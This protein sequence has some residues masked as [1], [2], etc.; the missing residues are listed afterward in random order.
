MN[1]PS[2]KII[3]FNDVYE[4]ERCPYFTQQILNLSN[5]HTLKI[6][7]GDIL[8]PSFVSNFK[9]G[10]QFIPFFQKIK[11]DGSV[12]GN[13]E[14]D[15]G[16]DVFKEITQKAKIEWLL[17]NYKVKD[18]D[19]NFMDCKDF[20]IKQIGNLKIGYFGIIDYEWILTSKIL[21]NEYDLQEPIAKTKE[22]SA[23]LKS[24]GC[25]FVIAI[26]HCD[27]VSDYLILEH[28]EDVDFVLGGHVHIYLAS[29]NSNRLM[30]KS[31]FDFNTFSE[32]VVTETT[33]SA[34]PLNTKS[35]TLMD[36]N[37][38]TKNEVSYVLQ[39]SVNGKKVNYCVQLIRHNVDVNGPYEPVLMEDLLKIQEEL[40]EETKEPL[41]YFSEDMNMR[42]GFIRANESKIGNLL[43]DLSIVKFGTDFALIQSGHIR[44]ETLYERR[45]CFR[46]VDL[47][48]TLPLKNPSEVS[49]LT[50]RE[51]LIVL[52]QGLLG[53]PTPKGSFPNIAGLRIEYD[54]SKPPM[55]RISTEKVLEL[56]PWFDLDKT[57]SLVTKDSVATGKDGYCL[58]EGLKRQAKSFDGSH[59]DIVLEFLMLAKQK[60]Y[61]DEFGLTKLYLDQKPLIHWH[62]LSINSN[63]KLQTLNSIS[64]MDLYRSSKAF[65]QLFQKLKPESQKRLMMYTLADDIL[66]DENTHFFK[67]NSSIDN[68]MKRL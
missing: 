40:K 11:M 18:T 2:F 50:G 37:D 52:N 3:H 28:C 38:F 35:E 46:L 21:T 26:T 19:H 12:P 63:P 61:R 57:Y 56:N 15:N 20:V 45:Y 7:S 22:M 5:D 59:Y 34:S 48:K 58:M 14:F 4:F 32:I 8:N 54:S 43:C 27:N 39:K 68:R 42:S 9:K 13:H 47:I 6:F 66:E 65:D 60:E 67:I 41:A 10:R 17:C 1:S 64:P 24:M 33:D 31:G 29:K 30:L 53:H 49:L 51:M 44:C 36:E 25:D 55:N 62:N 16:I 23:K